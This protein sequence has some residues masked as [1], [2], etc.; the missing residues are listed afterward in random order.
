MRTDLLNVFNTSLGLKSITGVALTVLGFLFDPLLA[1]VFLI[2]LVLTLIDCLL[3]YVRA[4][5]D[6]SHVTSRLMKKY[7]W[8]FVGYTIAT[9]SLFLMSNA[10]PPEIQFLTKWLDEFTLAFFAVHE[11]ISVIEHLN[12]MGIPM[13]SK[14]LSNLRKVQTTADQD[15][16]KYEVTKV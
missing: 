12:E 4:M 2:V 1:K 7:A 6:N 14:L 13:P 5:T 11:A 16:D 10:M 15:I 9:S 8:K 3:G